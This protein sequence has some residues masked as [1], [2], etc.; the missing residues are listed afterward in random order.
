MRKTM[1]YIVVY[2]GTLEDISCKCD[3]GYSGDTCEKGISIIY[4]C[5]CDKGYSGATCE[6]GITIIYPVNVIKATVVPP[7]RKVLL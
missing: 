5:K 2:A 7:V 1:V 6:K 3:K 4:S